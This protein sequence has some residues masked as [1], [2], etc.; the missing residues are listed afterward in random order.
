MEDTANNVRA[1]LNGADV[2]GL[3]VRTDNEGDN[4]QKFKH[5]I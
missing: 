5:E 3:T 2:T 1:S 4:Q